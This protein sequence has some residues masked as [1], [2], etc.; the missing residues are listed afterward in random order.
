MAPRRHGGATPMRVLHVN[1]PANAA[2]AFSRALRRAG[3]ES[4]VLEIYP[5][6]FGFP[7]DLRTPQDTMAR[8]LLAAPR[9]AALV[10]RYDVVH[11]HDCF[12]AAFRVGLKLA[13]RRRP[14]VAFHHHGSLLR[15]GAAWFSREPG[16]HF[17]STPDLLSRLPGARYLP[18]PWEPTPEPS[19]PRGATPVVV[20]HFPSDPRQ[21]G[22]DAVRAAVEPLARAGL[23]RFE[24]ASGVPHPEV[25][26]RLEACDVV[27]DQWRPDI[28]AHGVITLE[29]MARGK[30][31]VCSIER[32][33]YPGI[34]ILEGGP[35]EA[36][37]A[38][39]RDP[40][41][42]VATG[43]ASRRYVESVHDPQRVGETLLAWYR[44]GR[45]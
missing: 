14:T 32:A 16:L 45:R 39:A 27:V 29:A 4:D 9:L 3:V 18:I 23:V 34:P 19:Y 41:A 6:R 8:K 33:W 7:A 24:Y 20:G 11:F 2:W 21:K 38:A 5:S 22:T 15:S 25:L 40:A 31:V 13:G 28:G 10:G 12:P 17:V 42:L 36:L 37:A 43:R 1:N 44:E 30:A 26:K 35:E